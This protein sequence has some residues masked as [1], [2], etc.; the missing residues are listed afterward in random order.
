MQSRV[1]RVDIFVNDWPAGGC[2]IVSVLFLCFV[3]LGSHSPPPEELT[4]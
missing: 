1:E 2:V 4:S 3:L